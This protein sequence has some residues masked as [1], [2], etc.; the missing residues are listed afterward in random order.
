MQEFLLLTE[1]NALETSAQLNLLKASP[2][3]DSLVLSF[4]DY[5]ACWRRDAVSGWGRKNKE[6]V[7]GGAVK[8]WE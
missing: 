8:K 2:L 7:S 1:R 5:T 4:E 6:E 3:P